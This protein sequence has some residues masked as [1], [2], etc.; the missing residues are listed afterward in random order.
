MESDE[1]IVVGERKAW[2]AGAGGPYVLRYAGEYLMEEDAARLRNDWA[3]AWGE[4]PPQLIILPGELA[5]TQPLP[6][7]YAWYYSAGGLEQTF[8]FQ[9]L[10]EMAKFAR[11]YNAA[12]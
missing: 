7:R 10:D 3:D 1:P 12:V 5:M 8:T 11:E 4:N 9:T 6:G 2:P